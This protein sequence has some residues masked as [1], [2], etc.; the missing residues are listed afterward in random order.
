[1]SDEAMHKIVR[2]K[3]Q[4]LLRKPFFGYLSAYLSPIEDNT[5][6]IPTMRVDGIHLYYDKDFVERCSDKELQTVICHEILHCALGH[7]WRRGDRD[8]IVLL[9]DGT[10][11]LKWNV[12]T[13]AVVNFHLKQQGFELPDKAIQMP[14]AAN[15]SAEE[16]YLKIKV[17]EITAVRL[18]DDHSKWGK[19]GVEEDK[20]KEEKDIVAKLAAREK[21]AKQLEEKWKQLTAQARQIEKSQGKGMGSLEEMIDELIE[22]KLSWRELLRNVV[23]ASV[24]NDYRLIPPNKKHLWRGMY[25]PS[26]YGEEVEIG[27]AIDTSGSMSTDE[28][29]EGLS[30]L[31]GVCDSFSSYKI[32]LFQCDDGIQRYKELTPYNFDFPSEI[33]GRG[34]TSFVP[35]FEDIDK[36]GL[37]PS[38]VVYFTDGWGTVPTIKPPYSVIWLITERGAEE[39]SEYWNAMEK[40]GTMIRYKRGEK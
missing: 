40:I 26:T 14:E 33:R 31:K 34:G 16:L 35:V 24:K 8:E 29:R 37:R 10:P 25:L 6:I 9:P 39:G 2:A 7:V 17:K 13:D 28:V 23:V 20:E 27:Y 3:S 5:L 38:I 11:V 4:L 12:V 1:M 32:H 18:L 15:L 19:G 36:R 30:E 21:A 22:P